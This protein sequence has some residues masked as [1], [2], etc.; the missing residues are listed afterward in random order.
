MAD[1]LRNCWNL[2]SMVETITIEYKLCTCSSFIWDGWSTLRYVM[3]FRR[4]P[5]DSSVRYLWKF[6]LS[7]VYNGISAT[8]F[9]V[10]RKIVRIATTSDPE[11][12]LQ[13]QGT[14]LAAAVSCGSTAAV[15][16]WWRQQKMTS[17]VATLT[18]QKCFRHTLISLLVSQQSYFKCL[19]FH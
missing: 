9:C 16:Q 15:Q 14:R 13:Q 17:S 8:I 19:I 2:L 11:D 12:V 1:L 3:W 7:I 4:V 18:Y 5:E 10:T 6:L